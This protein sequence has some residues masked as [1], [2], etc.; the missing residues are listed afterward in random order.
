MFFCIFNKNVGSVGG[1]D[2]TVVIDI[3]EGVGRLCNGR[4]C[5]S[6]FRL[7]SG[8]SSC[9]GSDRGSGSF[10]RFCG[11]D[12]QSYGNGYIVFAVSGQSN[13]TLAFQGHFVYVRTACDIVI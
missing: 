9:Y 7:N 3:A 2:S 13:S 8:N 6:G 11:F 4:S 1:I 12:V 10:G 5:S